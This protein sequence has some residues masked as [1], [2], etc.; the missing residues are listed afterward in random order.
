MTRKTYQIQGTSMLPY[1]KAGRDTVLIEIREA[2][3]EKRFN[4]GDVIMYERNERYILHRIVGIKEDDFEAES[5]TAGGWTTEML[6]DFAKP[7][8]SFEYEDL[9]I[10]V[11]STD[12]RRVERILIC[13]KQQ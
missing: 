4:I 7:G 5:E 8:D 3:E 11:L 10:K 12:G 2:G 9:Q 6:G 13:R 1:L